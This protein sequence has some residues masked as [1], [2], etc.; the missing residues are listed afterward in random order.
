MVVKR[1]LNYFIL[2][3]LALSCLAPISSFAQT[4]FESYLRRDGLELIPKAAH[5]A[6]D[7]LAHVEGDLNYLRKEEGELLAIKMKIESYG[8]S[9]ID[10]LNHMETLSVNPDGLLQV[11]GVLGEVKPMVLELNTR[12]DN[13]IQD[14]LDLSMAMGL[15]AVRDELARAPRV[16]SDM[17]ALFKELIKQRDIYLE[18]KKEYGE[19]KDTRRATAYNKFFASLKP[20]FE[21]LE[22]PT[23]SRTRRLSAKI[24]NLLGKVGWVMQR[25]ALVGHFIKAFATVMRSPQPVNGQNPTLAA[26]MGLSRR[27]GDELGIEVVIEGKENLTLPGEGEITILVP[28]HREM[29]KDQIGVANLHFEDGSSD[30]D[31]DVIAPFAAAHV[32]PKF[33]VNRLNPNNGIVVVG[34]LARPK[35]I[36]KA[37]RILEETDLRM[38]MNY[39]G[40]RLPEGLGA[41]MG[42]RKKFFEM[43]SALENKGYK[44]NILAIAMR[45]NAKLFGTRSLTRNDGI[46]LKVAPVLKHETRHL[47]M[48]TAGEDA[49]A[50]MMRMGLIQDLVTNDEL[51]FGQV[52]G[53][54]LAS[55]LS[56]YLFGAVDCERLLSR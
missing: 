36:E 34:P 17:R 47:I 40:G 45:D 1:F 2:V 3:L 29:I 41:T 30:F 20:L 13:Y 6:D 22:R 42:V 48:E 44:V 28:S 31:G 38:F 4:R 53:S 25:P 26:V 10:F 33:I 11:R 15:Y 16:T 24:G 50:L 9:A 5:G 14:T 27:L 55:A 8:H 37:E 43:V 52:R 21:A 12:L 32:Y 18:N 35:P 54:M 7:F 51:I 56:E 23:L 46:T 49:V 19:G 39:A